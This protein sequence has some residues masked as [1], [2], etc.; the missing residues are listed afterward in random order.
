MIRIDSQ[1]NRYKRGYALNRN[2]VIPALSEV[3]HKLGEQ[4]K[5]CGDFVYSIDCDHCHTK[6]FGGFSSCRSKW[7][8][9]CSH[10]KS[11]AWI[12]KVIPVLKDWT[13]R[14]GMLNFTVANQDNLTLMIKTLNGGWRSMRDGYRKMFKARLP[15]GLRSLEVK[16]G[17]DGMWHAHMHCLIL[18]PPGRE[19]DFEW[20]RDAWKSI[21]GGSVWI[22]D[23]TNQKL[24]GVIEVVK[25]LI[26]PEMELYKD[27]DRLGEAV[28]SLKGKRQINTWGLL[29]GLSKEVEEL[30]NTFEERK[31]AAFVCTQ[32]GCNEGELVKMLY[33][34]SICYTLNDLK[35]LD[36]KK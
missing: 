28:R 2:V 14:V 30:E 6:H 10:K 11:L 27:A 5:S 20:I 4:L 13:G 22:K 3:D 34:D 12:A 31:L 7:C 8:V 17:K 33:R 35:V 1:F 16:V 36:Y 25:Y 18:Q 19:K 26:K 23:I 24:K 9:T 15:G 32:C 29:R 21:T